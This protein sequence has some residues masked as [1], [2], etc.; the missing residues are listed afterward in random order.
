[1]TEGDVQPCQE[2]S[3]LRCLSRHC[4]SVVHSVS[5]RDDDR[6]FE[7]T[8]SC[9]IRSAG[10]R[11]R[12]AG[13]LHVCPSP[14]AGASARGATAMDVAS[15]VDRDGGKEGE[16]GSENENIAEKR[17]KGRT[18]ADREEDKRRQC[19]TAARAGPGAP[20]RF[21]WNSQQSLGP[22]ALLG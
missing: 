20:S 6:P 2:S 19:R 13:G 7:L 1:M 12:R 18:A 22:T 15:L 8:G 11:R 17:R 3:P 4:A 5:S 14:S 16:G 10:C 21:P 9:L